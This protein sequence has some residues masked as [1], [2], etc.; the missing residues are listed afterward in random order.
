MDYTKKTPLEK[1][2]SNLNTSY[3]H[4]SYQHNLLPHI[5]HPVTTLLH[6]SQ[7]NHYN[8]HIH[9]PSPSS[10]ATWSTQLN[11]GMHLMGISLPVSPII[12]MQNMVLPDPSDS[13][14]PVSSLSWSTAF[15]EYSLI[16]PQSN[17]TIMEPSATRYGSLALHAQDQ[18]IRPTL[19]YGLKSAG[20]RSQ[21]LSPSEQSPIYSSCTR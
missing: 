18:T 17:T 7:E 20:K 5:D 15:V 16:R 13:V 6:T 10:D 3:R 8:T 4:L 19:C 12:C 2:S 1:T 9:T 14:M 11:M 21:A